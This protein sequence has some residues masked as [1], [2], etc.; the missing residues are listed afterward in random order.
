LARPDAA[1]LDPARYPYSCVLE[2]RFGDLDVN[3]HINNVAMA[4]LVEEA[5][6]RFHRATGLIESLNG[7]TVM[8]A[9]LNIAF[10]GQTFYPD[11]LD[12]RV[13]LAGA[14]R[15][16]Y[17]L[18]ILMLQRGVVVVQAETV[19]VCMGESG[20]TALPQA[21]LASLDPWNLKP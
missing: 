10:V 15:T 13:A 11:P 12:A 17:R 4:G 18:A 19:L 6:V 16:S 1:L 8:V 20:P 5:R 3:Q 14:G 21:W 7:L 2:P 9:A